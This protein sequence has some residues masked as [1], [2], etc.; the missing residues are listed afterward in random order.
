MTIKHK[1]WSTFLFLAVLVSSMTTMLL[2]SP[3][4]VSAQGIKVEYS[5]NIENFTFAF[6]KQWDMF[7]NVYN[8]TGETYSGQYIYTTTQV[9]PNGHIVDYIFDRNYTTIN[10]QYVSN[11]TLTGSFVF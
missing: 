10:H 11:R 3:A 4:Y 9:L 2:V 1:Q 6:E 7:S 8:K 5:S